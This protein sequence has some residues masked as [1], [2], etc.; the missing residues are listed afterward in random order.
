MKKLL[1]PFFIVLLTGCAAGGKPTSFVDEIL[2]INNS[3][4]LLQEVT[5]SVTGTGRS[6]SCGN[7]APLGICAN[8]FG[9]RRYESKP[10]E[11]SWI[12]GNV[13]RS[14][15]QFVLHVPAYFSMGIPMRG[16]L[17]I[18]PEGS[19]SAYFEQ[20]APFRR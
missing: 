6:F 5:V 15:E 11:I 16:V 18:S 17:E 13:E 12:F 14:T 2:I 19:I 7:I 20:D 4:E 8:R 10:I 3:R 9:A 1:I